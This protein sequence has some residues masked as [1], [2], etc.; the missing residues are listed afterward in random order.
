LGGF[1][2]IDLAG[3]DDIAEL[4]VLA[5]AGDAREQHHL[6]IEHLGCALGFLSRADVAWTRNTDGDLPVL[7]ALIEPTHGV[8]RAGR[9]A[10]AALVM[11]PCENGGRF[12][13]QSG[14]DD[15]ANHRAT[16]PTTASNSGQCGQ[17]SVD[18]WRTLTLGDA[19]GLRNFACLAVSPAVQD[20]VGKTVRV[21]LPSFALAAAKTFFSPSK[22]LPQR[23]ADTRGD[24]G[25]E[26]GTLVRNSARY[27]CARRLRSGAGAH[28]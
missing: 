27:G 9:V 12:K 17:N 8:L 15:D 5:S 18:R 22:Q 28:A 10:L 7:S 1:V 13:R 25:G 21:R 26:H 4:H 2:S 16:N 3:K 23:A 14:N 19:R 11:Q 6:R 24:C 20:P